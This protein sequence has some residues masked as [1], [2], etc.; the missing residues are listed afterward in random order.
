MRR[1]GPTK[2]PSASLRMLVSALAAPLV[3]FGCRRGEP[4]T[5]TD[6][7]T[8]WAGPEARV[9]DD[10]PKDVPI[11]PGAEIDLAAKGT[12]GKAAWSVTL[13]AADPKDRVVAYYRAHMRGFTV[14]SDVDV[15]ETHMFVWQSPAYDVTVMTDSA[16]LDK[17]GITVNVAA[18]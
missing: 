5:S 17:T 13:E 10:F 2:E 6:A 1:N 15:G 4:T 12:R 18:R 3:A 16:G 9:P 14:V 7:G 8:V 11:Y